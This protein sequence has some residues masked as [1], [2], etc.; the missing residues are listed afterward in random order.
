M[1]PCVEWVGKQLACTLKVTGDSVKGE[2]FTYDKATDTLVMKDHTVGLREADYRFI[3]GKDVELSSV[4]LD[5]THRV[6]EPSP[7]LEDVTVERCAL[8]CLVIPHAAPA[9]IL[10][11]TQAAL[12]ARTRGARR[13]AATAAMSASA[14]H[15]E[16]A[17]PVRRLAAHGSPQC[18]LRSAPPDYG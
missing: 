4:K 18:V 3:K 8:L 11:R 14:L 13:V 17:G 15:R 1:E 16:Q 10:A 9:R 12:A 7:A 5:G 6:P 2:V